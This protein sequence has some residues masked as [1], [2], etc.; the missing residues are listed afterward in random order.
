M[1]KLNYDDSVTIRTPDKYN[2]LDS[3]SRKKQKNPEYFD[4]TLKSFKLLS[5]LKHQKLVI[6]ESLK[7]NKNVNIFDHQILAAKK[8]INEFGCTGLLADEVG[9]GK[10]IEAGIIIKELFVTGL[11][12]NALILTPPSLVPQWQD[13]LSSKFNL[14]FIKQLDD[15]R[16][17]D[18]GSHDF[19]IMSHS[20]AIQPA[21]SVLLNKRIWDIVIVDE[22]HSMKNAD[23]QKHKTVKN[24][25]KKRLLLLSATPIQNN[26]QELYNIIELLHPSLL[27][28]WKEFKKKFISKNNIRELNPMYRSVLQEIISDVIIRN[29]RKEVSSYI[30]FTKRISNTHILTPSESE[31]ILYDS[32]TDKLRELY[33]SQF[34]AMAIMGYQ[35]YISSSNASTKN[36]LYKMKQNELIS[37]E[38]YD[39]LIDISKKIIIDSKMTH[40]LELLKNYDSKFLI[41]CEFLATQDYI[42]EVLEKNGYSTTLF[43]GKMSSEEKITSVDSFRNDTQ[44]LVSTG[45]GGEGQNFQFCHNI[46]NYDLPWNPMRVEQRIGRVHRIGQKNDVIIHNYAIKGTIE[47]YILELLYRKIELFTLTL[48]ELDIIFEGASSEEITKRFFH[49]YMTSKNKDEAENKF[50]VLSEEWKKNK[51]YVSNVVESFNKNVFKNFDLGTLQQNE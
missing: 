42:S 8:M 31:K 46:V 16:F 49:D 13:E 37:N 12:K 7:A 18:C 2:I 36:A 1:I 10:T 40:L 39:E 6:F 26:L 27:G 30:D 51:Q 44:I 45:A 17:V 4:L 3:L 23:T 29:T 20:S 48:G 35:K 33:S 50:S 43:N 34:G 38:E 47:A 41:F 9:L 14:D 15:E 32:I 28:T 11:I 25:I 22:A 24:L 19:L 5:I 21:N